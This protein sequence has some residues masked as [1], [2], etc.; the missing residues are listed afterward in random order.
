MRSSATTDKG[1]ISGNNPASAKIDTRGLVGGLVAY[2]WW[3]LSALYWNALG[4]VSTIDIIAHRALWAVPF[5]ALLL[6]AYGRLGRALRILRAPRQLALLAVCSALIALNWG[7]FVWS[8]GAGRLT[9]SSLGYFMQPLMAVLLGM[10]FFRER[11]TPIQ[12]LAV[13]FAAAG[14]LVFGSTVGQVPYIALG[15]SFSFG[16]YAAIKKS[17]PVDA[18]DGL[19]IETLLLAPAAL[20]WILWHAGAGLGQVDRATDVLLLLAGMFTVLP[21]I[22]FSASAR[23]LPLVTLGLLFYINPSIQLLLA[24][25]WFGEPVT[26]SQAWTFALV[27]SGLALYLVHMFHR[28]R[29]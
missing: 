12:W 20:V 18:L 19:F 21:L 5:C 3:G 4:S 6:I 28:R 23:R 8:V 16:I 24:V 15:V 29:S 14:V 10:V 13:A 2:V 11:L 1:R 25:C 26:I 22:A 17:L 7:L 27:W 9:E